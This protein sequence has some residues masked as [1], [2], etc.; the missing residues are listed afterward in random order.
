MAEITGP[1]RLV[2]STRLNRFTAAEIALAAEASEDDLPPPK[3][4]HAVTNYRLSY[5]TIDGF[6][7]ELT[8]SG[9]LSV[10]DKPPVVASPVISYQHGTIFY[11][12]EAPS[13]DASA[14]TVPV[15]LA[16][17]GFVVVA[18][19]YVGYGDS[20]GEEHPYLLAKPTAA[21]VLDL[22]TAAR[23]WRSQNHIADNG[24]LFLLGYSEGGYATM[25]AHRELQARQGPDP[26]ALV[27]NIAG[28]GPYDVG[29]T[30]DELL[31]RVRRDNPVLAALVSPGLLRNLGSSLRNEVRRALLRELIPEDADVSFQST[32]IDHF[33]ADDRAA[34]ERDCNVHDWRP[35]APLWMFHGRDD[36]TVPYAA[37]LSALNAM[38]ARAAPQVALIDCGAQPSSHLG[39]V[40]PYWLFMLDRLAGNARDL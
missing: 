6:G 9:L 8:A 40:A 17:M 21:A 36:E 29:V 38:Q 32:F 1:G 18:A 2:A 35:Q 25:A 37:A 39:C 10:P 28:A 16:S 24:Q 27:M 15:L 19:D 14:G 34:I 5:R 3:V 12:A 4:V 33:L 7:R 20:Q 23:S 30:L 31:R 13:V 26:D 22:L 11:N